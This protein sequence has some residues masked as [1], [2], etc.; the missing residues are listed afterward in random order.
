M[1]WGN[2]QPCSQNHFI[3]SLGRPPAPQSFPLGRISIQ[4][5]SWKGKA[6]THNDQGEKEGCTGTDGP[7]PFRGPAEPTHN[8]GH[9]M[10]RR[11][12]GGAACCCSASPLFIENSWMPAHRTPQS[13]L[14]S[15]L[16]FS[17]QKYSFFYVYK[18]FLYFIVM[19]FSDFLLFICFWISLKSWL[20]CL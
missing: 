17:P 2:I 18:T 3:H 19:I 12:G 5:W 13:M 1:Y 7:W 15:F 20:N 9:W 11:R 8:R 10:V 16:G 4:M 14:S 6:G